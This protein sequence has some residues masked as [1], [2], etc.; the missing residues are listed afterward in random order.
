MAVLR[1][2]GVAAM[3]T[4]LWFTAVYL[5]VSGLRPEFRHFNQ[6]VSELGALDAPYRWWWNTLGYLLPGLVVVA[7]ALALRQLLAPRGLATLPFYAL[8]ASGLFLSMSGLFPGDFEHRGALTMRLH[9]IGAYGSGLCFVVAAFWLPLRFRVVA[10]WRSLSLPTMALAVLLLLS[11]VL[12]DGAL[13]GLGQR[14]SFACLFCW[15]AVVGWGVFRE[16]NAG[17]P[18]AGPACISC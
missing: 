9:S 5:A 1:W 11:A 2:I 17:T 13:P 7:L 3:A 16:S 14:L 4:P 10:A 6:A 12:R 15:V 18:G 8:L